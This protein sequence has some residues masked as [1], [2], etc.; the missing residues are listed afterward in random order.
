[1]TNPY[2]SLGEENLSVCQTGLE[3]VHS[4]ERPRLQVSP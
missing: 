3:G 1:M 4:Q 2:D